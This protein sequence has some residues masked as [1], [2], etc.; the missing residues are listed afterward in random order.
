MF[1]RIRFVTRP[2]VPAKRDYACIVEPS[3]A[4]AQT[5]AANARLITL[6]TGNCHNRI[7]RLAVFRFDSRWAI[8]GWGRVCC[9]VNVKVLGI[10]PV[11]N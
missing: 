10:K 1:S 5:D 9:P 6:N 7:L 4:F 3:P 2:V 11:V 8:T